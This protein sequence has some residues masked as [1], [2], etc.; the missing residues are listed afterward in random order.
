VF[1]IQRSTGNHNL[2]GPKPRGGLTTVSERSHSWTEALLPLKTPLIL[3]GEL[4]SFLVRREQKARK[5]LI[6]LK[7]FCRKFLV[8]GGLFSR[9][10]L[11]LRNEGGMWI[12]EGAESG[13]E[14][15]GNLGADY[16]F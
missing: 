4:L 3:V 9:A 2:R 14:G 5:G 6:K 11:R 1:P 7:V 10:C 16:V 13:G 8:K 12:K 15:S